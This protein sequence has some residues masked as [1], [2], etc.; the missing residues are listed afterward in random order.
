MFAPVLQGQQLIPYDTTGAS[1]VGRPSPVPN[2]TGGKV[3]WIYK[4]P[5]LPSL[6]DYIVLDMS[7]RD[8]VNVGD[9]IEL[10]QPKQRPVEGRDL[11]LPEVS[12]A[13]A[14]VLRVT[15]FG[16]TAIITA[17][18]QPKIEEGTSARVAA[19]MP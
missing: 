4:E 10:Y 11:T 8:G 14:Q 18:E 19:K 15:A 13:R 5:V 1:P 6:Q 9:W 2:G 3:R 12:I 17:Q 7:K 16:A